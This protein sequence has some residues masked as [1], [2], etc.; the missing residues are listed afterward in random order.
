MTEKRAFHRIQDYNLLTMTRLRSWWKA[1]LQ[2]NFTCLFIDRLLSNQM[3]IVFAES[4]VRLIQCLHEC[5]LIAKEGGVE[6]SVTRVQF[7]HYLVYAYWGYHP[8]IDIKDTRFHLRFGVFRLTRTWRLRGHVYLAFIG[9]QMT[10]HIMTFEDITQ[11]CS[12]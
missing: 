8:T 6:R 7:F 11:R 12:V 5:R 1:V 10:R 2:R 4:A 9:I 3:P